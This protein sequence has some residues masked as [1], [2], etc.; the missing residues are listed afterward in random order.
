MQRRS[1]SFYRKRFAKQ[2]IRFNVN[3]QIRVPRVMIIDEN[4]ANLGEMDIAAALALVEERGYD[5]VEVQ[6][7][8]NPP[9]CKFLDYGQF[10]YEQEKHRQKQ[11]VKQKKVEIKGIR[12]SL[13]ISDHDKDIRLAQAK[14]F[15]EQGHKVKIDIVLRG[16]EKGHTDGAQS[17][18][19]DFARALGDDVF[20]EQPFTKQGGRLSLVVARK[21]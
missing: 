16:R 17:I 18:M 10:Q 14:K 2:Q 6:P 7:T 13:R 8:L 11:K 1:P 19:R 5:L 21:A 9:I 15:I 4:N 3:R 20:I 12:L